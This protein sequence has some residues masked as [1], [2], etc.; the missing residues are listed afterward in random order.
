MVLSCGK[1]RQTP[2]SPIT[3]SCEA[4]WG[5][6]HMKGVR[7]RAGGEQICKG[8]VLDFTPVPEKLGY[9]PL[10]KKQIQICF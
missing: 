1:D 8:F 5:C 2:G 6:F 9:T 7:S 10:V 3:P 4:V